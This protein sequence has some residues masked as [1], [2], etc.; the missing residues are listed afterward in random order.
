MFLQLN[1]IFERKAYVLCI[2]R[3]SN[4]SKNDHTTP[5]P[6]HSVL[7]TYLEIRLAIF[8]AFRTNKSRPNDQLLN[9]LII[10]Y[11][12]RL[13]V[14][15]DSA[16]AGTSKVSAYRTRELPE[17]WSVHFGEIYVSPP[18][19][20]YKCLTGR[21]GD[22]S[23]SSCFLFPTQVTWWNVTLR[24]IWNHVS[25]GSKYLK[26]W[27]KCRDG[28]ALYVSGLGLVVAIS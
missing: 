27:M 1:L 3:N 2:P 21:L 23:S 26:F 22:V 11:G 5:P 24:R 10:F 12:L 18:I 6:T 25:P 19:F 16:T 4:G 14:N 13:R 9:W 8:V 28:E 20:F 7:P 15:I 17:L